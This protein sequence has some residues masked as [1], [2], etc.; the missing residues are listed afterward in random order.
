MTVFA[1]IEAASVDVVVDAGEDLEV[2]A[3]QDVLLDGSNQDW[4]GIIY[5]PNGLIE[6]SGSSN[7]A[8]TGSLI[9][10]SVRLNGSDLTIIADPSLFPG[11]PFVALEE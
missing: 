10:Y 5:G 9:G 11:D 2:D 4:S 7:T 1:D 6:L 8:L 3:G